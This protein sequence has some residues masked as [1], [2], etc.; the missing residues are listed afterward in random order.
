MAPSR[1]NSQTARYLRADIPP[2]TADDRF[3]AVLA[4][5]AASSTPASDRSRV[6]KTALRFRIA[7]G[8]VSVALVSVGAAYAVDQFGTQERA[9]V[10]PTDT[11]DP[12]GPSEPAGPYENRVKDRAPLDSDEGREHQPDGSAG[13][14]DQDDTG[15]QDEEVEGGQPEAPAQQGQAAQD[16]PE[17]QESDP[18]GND[19]DGSPDPADDADTNPDADPGGPDTDAEDSDAEETDDRDEPDA[20]RDRDDEV[21]D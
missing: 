1:K 9:P 13:N 20:D 16:D 15:F 3:I 8:A 18:T 12:A 4:D 6:G 10:E 14:D 17:Q 19:P 11:I 5:L 2:V 21:D 7:A